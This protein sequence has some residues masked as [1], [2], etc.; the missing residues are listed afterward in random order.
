ML[1]VLTI[2]IMLATAYAFFGQGLLTAFA[3]TV[4]VLVAGL[5]AFCFFEPLADALR[6]AISGSPV[7]GYEEWI[8]MMGL[9]VISLGLL[10]LTT[11]AVA[12]SEPELMPI[13]QQIGG[14]LCGLVTG[15]LAAGFIVCAMQ[16]LP[17][18]ED[19]LGFSAKIEAAGG[20]RR[21][22]PPDR[23]WLAMMQAASTGPLDNDE[24]FDPHGYF[25]LSYQR[26]RR[27]GETRDP[28]RYAHE[29]EP[30]NHGE[31]SRE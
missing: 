21:Y 28:I 29:D 23:V 5:V 20:M 14:A 1:T 15:Y 16:T 6:Q 12:P 31:Q 27:F 18:A 9:F 7:E 3:M 11:N 30:V 4:N 8:C 24:T 22:L 26:H 19:F 10:R 17:I 25:E 13:L 2:L